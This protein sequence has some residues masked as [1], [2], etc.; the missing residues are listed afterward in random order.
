MTTP[1][2]AGLICPITQLPMKD[3]VIAMDGHTYE[4]EAIEQ[5]FR[6]KLTSPVTNQRLTSAM[7]IPN[8]TLRSYLPSSSSDGGG[9]G[10]GD[11]DMDVV[12][13]SADTGPTITTITMNINPTK[14]IMTLTARKSKLDPLSVILVMD[15]SGSMDFSSVRHPEKM[16]VAAST[17]LELVKHSANCLVSMLG[18]E[19]TFTLITFSDHARVR[20]EASAQRMNATNKT[21]VRRIIDNLGVEGG[22]NFM[23][24]IKE[25]FSVASSSSDSVGRKTQPVY[26]IFLTD[27][28]PTSL[29]NP[30][31]GYAQ[32]VN[33]LMME[34]PNAYL[35]TC[36]VGYAL[37]TTLLCDIAEKGNGAFYYIADGTMTGTIFVHMLA[38]MKFTV[39]RDV[40]WMHPLLPAFGGGEGDVPSLLAGGGEMRHG[41]ARHVL[42]PEVVASSPDAPTLSSSVGDGGGGN[43]HIIVNVTRDALPADDRVLA[44]IRFKSALQHAMQKAKR[45]A[46]LDAK[47]DML[48]FTAHLSEEDVVL[49][50][51]IF[52]MEAHKGQICKAFD[53]FQDWGYPYLSMILCAHEREMKVNFKDAS[54]QWYTS[55]EMEEFVKRSEQTFIRLP[56]PS[57]LTR[58]VGAVRSAQTTRGY[59]SCNTACF[60]PL[61]KIYL[62][63]GTLCAIQ[64]LKRGMIVKSGAIVDCLV[65]SGSGG[66]DLLSIGPSMEV[67]KW[68]PFRLSS[69]DEWCFPAEVNPDAETVHPYGVMNLLLSAPS[70]S[71]E[72]G[73]TYHIVEGEGGVQC[74]TLA[75]GYTSNA[76]VSHP[77]FGTHAVADDIRKQ[78][79]YVENGVVHTSGIVRDEKTGLVCGMFM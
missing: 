34:T 29:Y 4:R 74:V 71:E 13:P 41:V 60:S 19:D 20:S 56:P 70:S 8:H 51:D 37:D 11:A 31:M 72:E 58:R 68:H 75:H 67:T 32:A 61:S 12:T 49:R 23:A 18:D 44:L 62:A 27:G 40:E 39:L 42:L 33:A 36:G 26:I 22:T 43:N 7:L 5:W 35:Y 66:R 38:N 48:N 45:G 9:T 73:E 21:S 53:A 64:D 2:L 79:G 15:V 28:E 63:D 14:P 55:A 16:E 69:K 76:V 6:T 1:T 59:M 24:G 52:S 46:F 77:Y 30:P 3:P 78:S 50:E 10:G 65:I 25:A 54:L 17:R 47:Q 57:S